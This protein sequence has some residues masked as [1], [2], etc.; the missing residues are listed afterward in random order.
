MKTTSTINK[1]ATIVGLSLGAF[2]FSVMAQVWNPAP[3][4]GAPNDNVAAP[5][6]VGN[7]PEIQRK[8][9]SLTVGLSPS[10]ANAVIGGLSVGSLAAFG[11]STFD[12]D[13]KITSGTPGDKKV[14]TSDQFGNGTW[15]TPG[16]ITFG[17]YATTII[18][19]VDTITIFDLA[20]SRVRTSAK[21]VLVYVNSD[22]TCIDRANAWHIYDMSDRLVAKIGARTGA[23]ETV[24]VQ[25]FQAII[26]LTNSLAQFKYI[27]QDDCSGTIDVLAEIM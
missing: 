17:S 14:L 4:T 27:T 10:P 25:H 2:A 22:A 20:G 1:I 19:D 9:G 7:V 8:T 21:G 12:G 11:K 18:P 6:N 15:Q 3:S 5:I 16:G 26:P 24:S 13:V 23:N